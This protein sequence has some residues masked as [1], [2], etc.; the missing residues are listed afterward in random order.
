MT[1]KEWHRGEDATKH[2]AQGFSAVSDKAFIVTV[3][4]SPGHG[5][6]TRQ[7]ASFAHAM[8]ATV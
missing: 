2:D 1:T 3:L 5:A 6:T 4:T 8:P 7:T